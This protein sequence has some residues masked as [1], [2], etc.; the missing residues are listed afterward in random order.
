[1][2]DEGRVIPAEAVRDI[3]LAEVTP[4][5]RQRGSR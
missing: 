1:M 2:S 4:L 5:S 3:A